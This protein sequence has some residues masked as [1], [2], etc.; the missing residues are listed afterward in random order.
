MKR[1]RKTKY[2]IADMQR[3]LQRR[4]VYVGIAGVAASLFFSVSGNP[5]G[6]V[7]GNYLYGTYGAGFVLSFVFC[8]LAYGTVYSEDLENHYIRYSL[9]RGNLKGYVLTKTAAVFFSSVVVMAVGSA[10]FGMVGSFRWPWIDNE[11]YNE[12]VANSGYVWMAAEKRYILWLLSYGFQWGLLAGG[13]SQIA[14]FASLFITNRLLVLSVPLFAYQIIT[15]LSAKLAEKNSM[16]SIQSVFDARYQ[17]FGNDGKMFLW[18][19]VLGLG[20]AV[21]FGLASY[22]GIKKRM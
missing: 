20:T 1:G 2:F 4:E 10:L 17:M 22:F 15:E 8:T 12:L 16:W 21:L 3:L 6:T 11:I 5:Q 14:A 13:L 7:V 19:L 9:I 18:A